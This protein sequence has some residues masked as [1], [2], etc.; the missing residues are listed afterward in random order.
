[1]LDPVKCFDLS[2]IRLAY[3]TFR[4]MSHI[5]EVVID[6]D[7]CVIQTRR[8]VE[9]EFVTRELMDD[10]EVNFLIATVHLGMRLVNDE[11]DKGGESDESA[12]EGD[13]IYVIEAGFVAE[14]KVVCEEFDEESLQDFTS[15]NAPHVVWPFWRQHVC[16]TLQSASLPVVQVPLMAK[17]REP[18]P[19]ALAPTLAQPQ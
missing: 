10:V 18:R 2:N 14:F 13:P 15:K 5:G 8:W 3:S 16:G 12:E 7:K 17:V 4:T 11:Q 1:M 19:S 6:D 9:H